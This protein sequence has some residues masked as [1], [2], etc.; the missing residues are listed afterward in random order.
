[1]RKTA[2]ATAFPIDLLSG[3]SAPSA[4]AVLRKT[5]AAQPDHSVVIAQVGFS[6]NLARLLDSPP[7]EYSPLTGS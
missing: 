1:M 3:R 7:D 2:I 4:T 5:L 6:T